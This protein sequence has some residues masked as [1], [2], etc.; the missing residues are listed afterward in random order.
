MYAWFYKTTAFV[1]KKLCRRNS[2]LKITATVLGV[3]GLAMALIFA[4]L[5][6]NYSN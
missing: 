1:V 6:M 4:T 2:Y 5:A 3:I